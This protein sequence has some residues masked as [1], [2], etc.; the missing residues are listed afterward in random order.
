[1]NVHIIMLIVWVA[2]AVLF[3]IGIVKTMR[4]SRRALW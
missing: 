2:I 1:M 4:Q 3:F